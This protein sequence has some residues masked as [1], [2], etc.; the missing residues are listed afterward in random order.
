MVVLTGTGQVT[1]GAGDLAIIKAKLAKNLVEARQVMTVIVGEKASFQQVFVDYAMSPD[2]GGLWALQR[3]IGPMQAKALAFT[4]EVVGAARAKE[5]GMVYEVT[6][7][8]KALE[9]PEYKGY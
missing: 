4:G 5:L 8:G 9:A 1:F 2:T 6:E 3:L 7:G